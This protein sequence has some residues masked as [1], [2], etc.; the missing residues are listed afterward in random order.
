MSDTLPD[1]DELLFRQVHPNFVVD[2]QLSSQPFQP[3]DKDANKLSV[4]RSSLTDA[5]S[6]HALYVAN[7]FAS[8]GVYALSVGEFGKETL[9]C[10]SDPLPATE[11]SQANPAHAVADYSAHSSSK[12]KTIAK[13]LKQKA[14][15]RGQKHP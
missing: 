4:D 11:V 1:D 13:R 7:G 6:S 14:I 2:G 9:P 3:T 5:A 12:Q 10:V 15:E 8:A